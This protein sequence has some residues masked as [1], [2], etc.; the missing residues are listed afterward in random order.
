M[1][2]ILELGHCGTGRLLEF[3]CVFPQDML[4]AALLYCLTFLPTIYG[5]LVVNVRLVQAWEFLELGRNKKEEVLLHVLW[6]NSHHFLEKK[7]IIFCVR[8]FFSFGYHLLLYRSLKSWLEDVALGQ[9]HKLGR[10]KRLHSWRHTVVGVCTHQ[11]NLFNKQQKTAEKWVLWDDF[12]TTMLGNC[13]LC[14]S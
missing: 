2:T 9:E 8:A 4:S 3:G 5:K 14:F 11:K 1:L 12:P 13:S 7:N 6:L 10:V